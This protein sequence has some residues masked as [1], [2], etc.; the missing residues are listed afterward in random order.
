MP[1]L[2]AHAG[3]SVE[4]ASRLA[5]VYMIRKLL[6]R[7]RGP[8][9]PRKRRNTTARAGYGQGCPTTDMLVQLH[10]ISNARRELRM[11]NSMWGRLTARSC[12]RMITTDSANAHTGTPLTCQSMQ[13]NY[14]TGR[15]K[16]N[17]G[18]MQPPADRPCP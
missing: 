2:T 11:Q 10:C 17:T 1:P 13:I 9:L 18:V 6:A 5:V 3:V 16:C 4:T 8:R 7:L 12:S 15:G 14:N